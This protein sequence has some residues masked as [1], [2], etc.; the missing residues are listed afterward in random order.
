MEARTA[1]K[2]LLQPFKHEILLAWIVAILPNELVNRREG[3]SGGRQRP[4]LVVPCRPR[5]GLEIL[6]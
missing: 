6:Y 3:G 5:E 1:M 2:R 4:D